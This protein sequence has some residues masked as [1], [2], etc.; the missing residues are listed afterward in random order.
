MSKWRRVG[1]WLMAK[2]RHLVGIHTYAPTL[3]PEFDQD[4]VL[5]AVRFQDECLVCDAAPGEK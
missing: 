2:L 5:V 1:S 3:Y 4:E